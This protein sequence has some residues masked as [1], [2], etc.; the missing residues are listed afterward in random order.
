MPRPSRPRTPKE[1]TDAIWLERVTLDDVPLE[2]QVAVQTLGMRKA[3][4]L[5]QVEARRKRN[6]E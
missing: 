1:W 6:G 5:F 4:K 3:E 2:K